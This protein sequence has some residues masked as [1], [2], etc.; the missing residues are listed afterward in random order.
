MCFPHLLETSF[1]N[2]NNLTVQKPLTDRLYILQ[3]CYIV[4]FYI[5]TVYTGVKLGFVMWGGGLYGIE[6]IYIYIYIYI[7]II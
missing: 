1:K 4:T 3:K 6:L 5:Y 2:I 7:Y